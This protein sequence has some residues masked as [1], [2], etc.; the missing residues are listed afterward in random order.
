MTKKW[1]VYFG[2]EFH[3]IE[4]YSAMNAAQHFGDYGFYGITKVEL[5]DG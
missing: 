2:T 1:K 4:A 3:I 5:V